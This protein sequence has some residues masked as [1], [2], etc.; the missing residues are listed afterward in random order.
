MK[1]RRRVM[2]K[3]S[4][5]QLDEAGEKNKIVTQAEGQYVF[6]GG[7]HYVLY[8]D[9]E[10]HDKQTIATVLKFNQ[11]EVNLLRRG[12]IKSEQRFVIGKQH[13]SLYQTPYGDLSLGT[14]TQKLN[15]DYDAVS[16]GQIKI[17]YDMLVNGKLQSH[18]T[19]DIQIAML[20]D[21]RH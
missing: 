7:K 15:V 6:R 17:V 5:I 1:D 12:A 3:V 9:N 14:C 11:S 16:G 21:G 4:G 19:L 20:A 10:L 18:N 13:E 8:D 2:I